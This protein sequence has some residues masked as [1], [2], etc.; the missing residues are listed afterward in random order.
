MRWGGQ[1]MSRASI[2]LT[3]QQEQQQSHHTNENKLII[4]Y[5]HTAPASLLASPLKEAP[6]R[7][8]HGLTSYVGQLLSSPLTTDASIRLQRDS[9]IYRCNRY[10]VVHRFKKPTPLTA[11]HTSCALMAKYLV[12]RLLRPP[13][14]WREYGWV[15]PPFG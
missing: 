4:Q 12:C 3:T 7:L 13:W 14:S 1:R 10:A 15:W 9:P 11:K 5:G 2:F 8:T 6:L